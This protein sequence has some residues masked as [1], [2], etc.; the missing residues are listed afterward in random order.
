MACE[1]CINGCVNPQNCAC[2][3]TTCAE[4]NSCDI[5]VGDVGPMGP[6][7]PQ[8]PPGTNGID[9]INGTDGADGCTLVDA[10]ISDGTDGN[11]DGDLIITTGPTPTPCNQTIN[12]GNILG[13]II[14]TG[15]VIPAGIIVMW[16]GAI[17]NIPTGWGLCDGSA[18]NQPDLR[19]KFIASYKAGDP[20]FGGILGGGGSMTTSLSVGN[21][22]AHTHNIGT[23]SANIAV[24]GAHAHRWRG[25]FGVDGTPGASP[26]EDCKSR[27]RLGGD[28]PDWVTLR[29]G[30]GTG[31][32]TGDND[33]NCGAHSHTVTLSGNSGDGTP[34][35]NAPQG[36]PFNI[37]PEYVT[38][39]FIIKL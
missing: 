28:P 2:D 4:A 20:N 34:L 13:S 6:Q 29:P 33:T 23:Y 32:C 30:D 5:P 18:V 19:G 35:L 24:S 16:S 36:L 27:L 31:D 14:N 21:I 38:L 37:I 10:Y 17:G 26:Q 1:S 22:P 3:C 12:A 25:W 9:G 39:A 11:A 7:G 15:A 8:G